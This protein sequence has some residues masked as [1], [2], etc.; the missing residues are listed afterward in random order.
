M[1]AESVINE[2]L[3]DEAGGTLT[4]ES[5]Q[6][7]VQ[8]GVSIKPLAGVVRF[9]RQVKSISSIDKVF[10]KNKNSIRSAAVKAVNAVDDD[11]F[12]DSEEEGSGGNNNDTP[13]SKPAPENDREAEGY[14]KSLY[15]YFKKVIKGLGFPEMKQVY[16]TAKAVVTKLL[17]GVGL[18]GM[19][20]IAP[21]SIP[22]AL[23]IVVMCITNAVEQT[24]DIEDETERINLKQAFNN[25]M[26]GFKKMFLSL[27]INKGEGKFAIISTLIVGVLMWVKS[28]ITDVQ[29]VFTSAFS[30]IRQGGVGAWNVAKSKISAA[31]DLQTVAKLV[32]SAATREEVVEAMIKKGID[33]KK[34]DELERRVK[35]LWD[36]PPEQRSKQIK[37]I[38]RGHYKKGLETAGGMEK[39]AASKTTKAIYWGIVIVGIATILYLFANMVDSFN[40]KRVKEREDDS[41]EFERTI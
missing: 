14:L 8:E 24:K 6:V 25:V 35:N 29:N 22:I 26:Q 17:I 9:L 7:Y 15:L 4:L 5:L 27:K 18:V 32:T 31:T 41:E 13:V 40:L 34:L 30:W 16:R 37:G 3:S 2:Y 23:I 21:L 12:S 38:I 33:P 36:L 10:S 11:I 39:E 1:S 20:V 19:A 28:Q